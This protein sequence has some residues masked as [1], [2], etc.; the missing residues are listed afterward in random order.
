MDHKEQH[1]LKHIKERDHE[2]KE[3]QEHEREAERGR[4]PFH[5]AWLFVVGAVAVIVA[6]RM[7]TLFLA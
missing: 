7:W 3:Y 6:M 1:H 4:L 5:P 2:K